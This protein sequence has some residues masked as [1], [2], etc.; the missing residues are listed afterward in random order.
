MWVAIY[1]V[2]VMVGI[3]MGKMAWAIPTA[4]QPLLAR[5]Y[6]PLMYLSALPLGVGLLGVFARLDGRARG[7]GITSVVFAAVALVMC[8]INALLLLISS[9]SQSGLLG[10]L[11]A[12]ANAFP[13]Y[14]SALFGTGFLGWA[15]LRAHALSRSLAWTLIAIAI[16]TVPILFTTPLPIGP[17]WA[18]DAL[19][20]LLSGIGYTIVGLR[21]P[22]A[23]QQASA[24]TARAAPQVVAQAK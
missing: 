15:A 13:G 1:M 18:T 22:S 9:T 20:F 5:F 23:R 10:G 17:D 16:V 2:M 21:M 24:A 11:A 3:M 14:I 7:L 8:L 12:V 4:Q 6:Y 19:A